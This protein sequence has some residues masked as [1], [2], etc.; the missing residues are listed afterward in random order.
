MSTNKYHAPHQ[1]KRECARRV[2][3][4]AKLA[5]KKK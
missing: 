1:N 3:Q 5:A 4:M 2:R